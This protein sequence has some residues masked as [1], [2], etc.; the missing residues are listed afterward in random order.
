MYQDEEEFKKARD[1]DYYSKGGWSYKSCWF[2]DLDAAKKY[3][4]MARDE[5]GEHWKWPQ[6]IAVHWKSGPVTRRDIET[7]PGFTEFYTLD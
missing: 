2:E 5:E 7:F 3:I 4:Q 1:E 6:C